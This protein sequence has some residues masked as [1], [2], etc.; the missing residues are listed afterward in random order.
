VKKMDKVDGPDADK[1]E[2]TKVELFMDSDNPAFKY[3]QQFAFFKDGSPEEWIK[4]VMAFHEIEYLIPLKEPADKTSMFRTLLKGQ[5]LSY[6]EHHLR[7]RLEAEDLEFSDKN[8]IELVL[9]DLDLEYIPRYNI[10]MQKYYMRQG[11]YMT[12]N[13][14]LQKFVERLNYLNCYL[15]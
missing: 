13:K 11:L 6:F 1:T 10:C 8:L 2:W 12:L 4:W 9:R 5:A 15:I 3:S 14:S 7:R